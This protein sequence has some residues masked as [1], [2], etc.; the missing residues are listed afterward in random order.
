MSVTFIARMKI[1]PEKE[2]EYIE[3]CRS[4]EAKVQ[5]HEPETLI[6]SFYRLEEA[7][8]FAVLESFTSHQ[9]DEDHQ[10]TDYFKE[11]APALIA[12]LDGP[13]IRE[14]LYPLEGVPADE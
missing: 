1:H 6:Y 13:Y 2:A 9:A 3:L 12:C 5:A 4:L 8:H 14:Y 10:N 7:H 11:I